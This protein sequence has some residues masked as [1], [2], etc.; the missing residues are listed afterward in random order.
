MREQCFVLSAAHA[1]SPHTKT[2]L[3]IGCGST[4]YPLT[5][6]LYFSAPGKDGTHDTDPIDA[7][8][9]H[10]TGE[11]PPDIRAACL[12]FDDLD[13]E[14]PI[15]DRFFHVVCGFRSKRS[16]VDAASARSGIERYC[17][18][19]WSDQ[20][21]E[22]FELSRRRHILLGFDK[23]ATVNGELRNVPV[24][25]GMSGG[26]VFKIHGVPGRPHQQLRPD[27][28]PS[29][30]VAAIFIEAHDA[31]NGRKPAMV[32]TRVNTH[33]RLIMEHFSRNLE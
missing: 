33:L 17:A 19:E 3:H 14:R 24:P 21:Y 10:L 32:G 4:I 9:L 16:R 26:A 25:R 28:K 12:S 27:V 23:Q 15:A 7:V 2:G 5:G 30:K 18:P 22:D 1:F 6:E 11:V 31:K 20:V 8:V 13:L 29:A